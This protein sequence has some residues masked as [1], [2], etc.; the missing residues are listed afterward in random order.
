MSGYNTAGLAQPRD[1]VRFLIATHALPEKISDRRDCN[2]SSPHQSWTM[3]R[4][5]KFQSGTNQCL[6]L[7]GQ[8]LANLTNFVTNGGFF[9]PYQISLGR[10]LTSPK[11][12]VKMPNRGCRILCLL[13]TSISSITQVCFSWR[14]ILV[15]HHYLHLRSLHGSVWGWYD[16]AGAALGLRLKPYQSAVDLHVWSWLYVTSECQNSSGF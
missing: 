7:F 13:V 6:G 8:S 5:G 3:T 1:A 12:V 11:Y 4:D 15:A 14:Y 9:F 10:A 2:K 16:E